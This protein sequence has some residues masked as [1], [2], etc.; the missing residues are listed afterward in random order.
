VNVL[1]LR[2]ADVPRDARIGRR[3][4][5]ASVRTRPFARPHTHPAL[6][7]PRKLRSLTHLS[8]S[9]HAPWR[10]PTGACP[11]SAVKASLGD[12]CDGRMECRRYRARRSCP[13]TL[14]HV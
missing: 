5:T 8:T 11:A 14:V 6:W 12:S 2:D 1:L 10:H 7:A 9:F 4:A 13:Q 3:A